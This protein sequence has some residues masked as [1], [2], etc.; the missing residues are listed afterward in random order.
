MVFVALPLPPSP[1]VTVDQVFGFLFF[2]VLEEGRGL[3]TLLL[4]ADSEGNCIF[5]FAYAGD[6]KLVVEQ[7]SSRAAKN[8]D[9]IK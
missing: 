8:F 3:L 2:L 7:S 5:K 6:C 1:Y 4:P 9:K